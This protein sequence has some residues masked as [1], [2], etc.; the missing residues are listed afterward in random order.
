MMNAWLFQK[1]LLLYPQDL[2]REFGAEMTLAFAEDIQNM[3]YLRVWWCAMREL[4][5]VALPGQISNRSVLV[6][7]LSFVTSALTESAEL[8]IGIHQAPRT[9]VAMLPEQILLVVLLPSLLNAFV[10]FVVTRFYAR[11][12]F[13]MLRLD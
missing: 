2:R 3:G 6:P 11:C 4:L 8:C 12:S 10:A 7:A 9:D 5:T 1:M 13:I